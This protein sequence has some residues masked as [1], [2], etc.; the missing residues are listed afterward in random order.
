MEEEEVEVEENS[1]L[2]LSCRL[3]LH[4]SFSL[5]FHAVKEEEKEEREKE[6]QK[7]EEG[8]KEVCL[9][10]AALKKGAREFRSKTWS[11]SGAGP[12]V[13]IFTINACMRVH[14]CMYVRTY[15]NRPN[16]RKPHSL[17]HRG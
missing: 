4:V 1:P 13:F 3:S 10:A 16:A 5:S 8:K 11:R 9:G 6:R 14:V 12:G 2:T 15:S 17:T 7:E